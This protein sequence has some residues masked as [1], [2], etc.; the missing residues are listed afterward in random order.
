MAGSYLQ[1][2]FTGTSTNADKF[3][4]S[5]WV[6]FSKV[7]SAMPIMGNL[8]T[9]GNGMWV[10]YGATGALTILEYD[11]S[12]VWQ[13]ATNRKFLDPTSWYH[14]VYTGDSTQSTA[15][16]RLKMYV[17]GVQET[18]FSSSTYAAQNTDFH[19]NKEMSGTSNGHMIGKFQ[20]AATQKFHGYLAHI[21]NI[22]GL[23]YPASTFGSTDATTG[24]WKP[25]LTPSVTYGT[26]GFFLK[27]E[28][29]GAIGTDS[30]GNTNT[31]TG[32]GYLE[33]S[34]STPSND[35]CVLNYHECYE[36]ERH[37]A[38]LWG[39]T[40]WRDADYGNDGPK[41]AVGTLAAK[42][43]KWYFECKHVEGMYPV[44]G[45]SKANSLAAG[46]TIG[47]H[48]RS[49]FIQGND[50]DGFGFQMD[51]STLIQ[52]GDNTEVQWTDGSSNIT[53]FADGDICMCAYDL[54][55]GKIWWGKNGTWNTVPGSTTTTSSAEIASGSNA[56]KTWTANGEFF[57]PAVS[58]YQRSYGGGSG[59]N[60]NT[61]Y[62]NFGEG[63]FAD[64]DVSSGNADSEGIGVF[65]YAPPTG[66]LAVCT[67]NIKGYGG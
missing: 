19:F 56:H 40:T 4:L 11:G 9:A 22:D 12:V 35:F 38:M 59:A 48:Y 49:P 42:G 6:K 29:A 30:S 24:G 36:Y 15:A 31:F 28:N 26:N 18:S 34:L 32:S 67:R 64:T 57:R 55:A 16:D 21:N 60:P 58:V 50:G 27:F 2:D 66:F 10:E 5:F 43:G 8:N 14:I 13:L 62:L 45:I 37:M 44:C 1:W 17:N 41:G 39:G 47:L 61:V 46:E 63:R 23:A 54:D 33:Q 7:K 52:R 51:T 25:T 20:T 65:E 3:T 53:N